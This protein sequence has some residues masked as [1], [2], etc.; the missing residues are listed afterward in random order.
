MLRAVL[1]QYFICTV[2]STSD[3]TLRTLYRS[4]F[5]GIRA[6]IELQV[7][8]MMCCWPYVYGH[9]VQT[10]LHAGYISRFKNPDSRRRAY[11]DVFARTSNGEREAIAD[12][13]CLNDLISAITLW[14]VT[15]VAVDTPLR[16]FALLKTSLYSC[17]PVWNRP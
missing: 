17:M 2:N 10:S 5:N 12:G 16:A 15:C 11:F 6:N 8:S 4:Y 3:Y 9:F 13:S 7:Y 1:D 14:R